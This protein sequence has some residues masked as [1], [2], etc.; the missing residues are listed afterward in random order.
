[1]AVRNMSQSP[2]LL[3]L[4][5]DRNSNY[6]KSNYSFDTEYERRNFWFKNT[7]QERMWVRNKVSITNLNTSAHIA[8]LA[9]TVAAVTMKSDL[10]CRKL[11]TIKRIVL[12]KPIHMLMPRKD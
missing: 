6:F 5:I 8:L 3:R 9:V 4:P 12:S 1:M 7:G 2:M 10:Y 11:K